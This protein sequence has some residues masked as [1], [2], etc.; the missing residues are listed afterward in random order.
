MGS[1]ER[2][3]PEEASVEEGSGAQVD[4]KMPT[5]MGNDERAPL[6]EASV[7]K[8]SGAQVDTEVWA[9]PMEASVEACD[10]AQI[11]A[12]LPTEMGKAPLKASAEAASDAASVGLGCLDPG[13]RQ[14]ALVLLAQLTA[15]GVDGVCGL[16]QA[17]QAEGRRQRPRQ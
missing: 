12:A 9:P 16:A 10:G 17:L 1:D 4:A 2:A 15:L 5:K 13:K 8:G 7:E 3:P 14:E 11:D 6:E